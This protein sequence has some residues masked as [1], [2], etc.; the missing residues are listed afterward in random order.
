MKK[1]T[2]P[3]FRERVS[4]LRKVLNETEGSAA[5]YSCRVSAQ[6]TQDLKVQVRAGKHR[7][8]MDDASLIE[9]PEEFPNPGQ[10]LL[11]A[12]AACEVMMYLECAAVM[13]IPLTDVKVAVEGQLDLRPSVTGAPG[14]PGFHQIDCKITVTTPVPM[15]RLQELAEAVEKQCPVADTLRR[16]CVV[17][18]EVSVV[19]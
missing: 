19:T 7:F 3:S 10:Y 2:I 1:M 8:T 18:H 13:D 11:G 6:W 5:N 17:Q 4:E 9:E 16:G 14:R 12:L 15:E